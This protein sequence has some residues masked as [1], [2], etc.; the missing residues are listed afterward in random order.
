MARND[1]RRRRVVMDEAL[2]ERSEFDSAALECAGPSDAIG[3]D[4]ANAI[5][6]GTKAKRR[7]QLKTTDLLPK[8]MRALIGFGVV[9]G[10]LIAAINSKHHSSSV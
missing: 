3:A 1:Q 5:E 8:R 2:H 9:L 4:L 7:N 6:Y 10:L